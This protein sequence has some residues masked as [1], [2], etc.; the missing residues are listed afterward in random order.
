MGL[1]IIYM[2][3]LVVGILSVQAVVL[4]LVYI[5]AK[6]GVLKIHGDIEKFK[7][8]F[9][10]IIVPAIVVAL[11]VAIVGLFLTTSLYSTTPPVAIDIEP[12]GTV[13]GFYTY[14]VSIQVLESPY[15]QTH[16]SWFI[17]S[18]KA[19][20]NNTPVP[21]LIRPKPPIGIMP[22]WWN[23]DTVSPIPMVTLYCPRKIT[24]VIV[25]TS[26]ANTTVNL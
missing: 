9:K 6:R 10:K 21:C 25:L 11:A 23:A 18:V 13:N 19:Y 20:A 22:N 2:Y 12:N 14:V 8:G 24:R 1:F 26:S 17:F 15:W 7:K 3:L 5:E 16:M 4:A